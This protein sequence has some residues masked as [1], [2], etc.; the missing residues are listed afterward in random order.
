MRSE[1]ETPV[2]NSAGGPRGPVFIVGCPRSGTSALSWA[3][4]QHPD[5]WVSAESDFI[6]LLFGY[7][8]M[9]KAYR[10]AHDRPDEGWLAKNEVGY[11]E[12]CANLGLG[13]DA[14]FRSRSGGARWIDSSPGYTL[15]MG[16]LALMFPDARF[17]HLV[18]DGRA[19]VNSMI[20]SGFD[21]DWARDFE[22]ACFTWAHYVRKGIEFEK[23]WADRAFR[24]PHGDLIDDPQQT[25]S[26]ILRFLGEEHDEAPARFLMEGRINSSYDNAAPGD[27]RAVKNTHRLKES[28]WVKWDVTR[29]ATFARVAGDAMRLAG[30]AFEVPSS[31]GNGA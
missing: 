15:M 3:L 17:V 19:V 6:Q 21:I 11:P 7:G 28:P 13:V 14:L 24:V 25:C 29:Q 4:A 23:I 30:H 18:R 8:H 2:G 26:D 27:I 10:V 20:S 5:M 22:R 31:T 16:E 9:Q 12:F 1:L